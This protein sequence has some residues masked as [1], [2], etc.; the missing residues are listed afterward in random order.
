MVEA[1][2]AVFLAADDG[3]FLD[4]VDRF[5]AIDGDQLGTHGGNQNREGTLTSSF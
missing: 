2:I 1:Q 5:A 3:Q 4:E